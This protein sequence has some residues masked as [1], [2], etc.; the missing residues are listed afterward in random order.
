[1]KFKKLKKEQEID[2]V[3]KKTTELL[4]SAEALLDEIKK[5]KRNI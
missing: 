5:Q 2:L 1:M 4:K 3:L